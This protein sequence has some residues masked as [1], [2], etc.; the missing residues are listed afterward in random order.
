MDDIFRT[1]G[2]RTFGTAAAKRP[3]AKPTAATPSAKK[4]PDPPNGLFQGH[5]AASDCGTP[6]PASGSPREKT[7]PPFFIEMT[8]EWPALAEKLQALVDGDIVALARGKYFRVRTTTIDNFRKLQRW[9]LT[10]KVPFHTFSCGGGRSLK[11]VISGLPAYV[12]EQDLVNALAVKNFEASQASRLSSRFGRSNKFLVTFVRDSEREGKDTRPAAAIYR[13]LDLF[14]VRVHVASYKRPPGPPQCYICQEYGHGS[15]NC[16]RPRRCVTCGENHTK[17][18]CTVAYKDRKC[19]NCGGS[20]QANWR[21]CPAFATAKS[22]AIPRPEKQTTPPQR[23]RAKPSRPTPPAATA[24][25]VDAPTTEGDASPSRKRRKRPP[26]NPKNR[27]PLQ[28]GQEPKPTTTTTR[29]AEKRPSESAEPAP[30][31]PAKIRPRIPRTSPAS[32]AAPETA[33]TTE[34]TSSTDVD[35]KTTLV[36]INKVLAQVMAIVK[37]LADLT[38]R[39]IDQRQ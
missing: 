33:A 26:R 17:V 7:P 4:P 18:N 32:G 11:V 6:Q 38:S 19:C 22:A 12:T 21:G 16:G 39:L 35:A 29:K 28:D 34:S 25:S 9:L 3:A 30:A 5:K 8:P 27:R 15:A 2:K 14:H 23:P 20:H 1:M 37:T 10:E 13:L 31:S 24:E 36:E